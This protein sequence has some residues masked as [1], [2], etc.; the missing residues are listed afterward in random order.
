[1]GADRHLA[2]F[3]CCKQFHQRPVDG[4]SKVVNGFH[5]VVRHR[6]NSLLYQ[7]FILG[8]KQNKHPYHNLY[9]GK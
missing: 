5:T 9:I 8:V 6:S 3:Y 4:V 1:M 2:D 7:S